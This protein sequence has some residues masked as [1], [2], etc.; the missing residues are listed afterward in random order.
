MEE[1]V[2]YL[3]DL[4]AED[5]YKSALYYYKK[6]QIDTNILNSNIE[7]DAGLGLDLGWGYDFGTSRAEVTWVRGQSDGV[8]WLGYTIQ[9]D[10]TIDSLLA[11]YFYDFRDDKQ[12]RPF[13]GA[14]IGSTNVDLD[15]ISDSGFTYGLSYGLS[16]KTSETMDV[17]FKG[18]TM[19]IPELDFGTFT[20]VNG[21]YTNGTIGMRFRF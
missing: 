7:F 17:F 5:M 21:N 8:S 3:V 13:L 4:F 12:W 19:I 15:G 18:Q 1:E 6:N 9:S 11:S 20:I 16:Y 2:M 14:S 10:S